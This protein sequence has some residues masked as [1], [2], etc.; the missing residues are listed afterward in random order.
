MHQ[1]WFSLLHKAHEKCIHEKKAEI[2]KKS[3]GK[4][5]GQLFKIAFTRRNESSSR[6]I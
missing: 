3:A 2:K 5:G 6:V 1:W 4:L